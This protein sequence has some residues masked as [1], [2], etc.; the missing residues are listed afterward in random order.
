MTKGPRDAM[1]VDLAEGVSVVIPHYGSPEPTRLL[2]AALRRGETARTLQIIV[3]DDASPDPLGNIEGA[4]LLRQ[5]S[6]RGFGAAVNAGVERAEHPL[7]LILNSDVE[8]TD[9]FVDAFVRAAQPWLPAVVGPRVLGVDG[10]PAAT[11]RRFP[12]A[13]QQVVEWLSLGARWRSTAPVRWAVGHDVSRTP[14]TIRAV[15]WLVGAALLLPTDAFRSIGGFDPRFF[16]NC[17]EVDLQ[18]RL[19]DTGVPSI[20]A[21]TVELIHR[22]G[23]SSDPAL[24]RSWLVRSR[25]QYAAKW[26]GPLAA[27]RLRA[28][29]AAASLVNAASNTAR[30]ACGRPV[31]PL[32][33]LRA[34]LGLL[35]AAKDAP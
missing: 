30:R 10:A 16:M 14:S 28:A 13:R 11:A 9:G 21:G 2:V 15:D 22:S 26:D 23:G 31:A 17:E 5:S 12:T 34:E 7:L 24:R 4:E 29:L 6:N 18:R 33:V 27:G 3:V 35:A 32:A 25:V 19:R 1:D 20:F 8:I